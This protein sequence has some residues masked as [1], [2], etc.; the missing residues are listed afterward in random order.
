MAEPGRELCQHN[1]SVDPFGRCNGCGD[2]LQW[3]LL[4]D[5]VDMTA[6]RDWAEGS[7]S[8]TYHLDSPRAVSPSRHMAISSALNGFALHLA[9][10]IVENRC[11]G[12]LIYAGGDDVMALV[13]VDDLLACLTLLRAAYGGLPLPDTLRDALALDLDSPVGLRLGGGHALLGERLIRVM[14]ERATASAGAVIAH[15]SAPLGAVLRTLR[16]AE[17][18]AKH[19]GGRD[20]FSIT[21]VKRGGGASELT[22]PWRLTDA[23]SLDALFAALADDWGRLDF[24]VHAIAFADKDK[25]QS[26]AEKMAQRGYAISVTEAGEAGALRVRLGNFTLRDDAERQLRSFRQEGLS[27][28]IINLPQAFR[29]EVRSSVP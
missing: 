16:E 18:R 5:A 1:G 29:P 21:L 27:G 15:H 3:E 22:L 28:I 25:A 2:M 24:V 14:G 19:K 26:W 10:D 7:V 4:L 12:K 6:L 13:A 20:A 8:D 11:K 9:Q 17:K 23:A